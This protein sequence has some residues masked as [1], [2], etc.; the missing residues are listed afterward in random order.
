MAGR[1]DSWCADAPFFSEVTAA[2]AFS[3]SSE[4]QFYYVF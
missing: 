4:I 3:F 2:A 1:T